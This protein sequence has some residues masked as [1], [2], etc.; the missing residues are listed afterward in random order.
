MHGGIG[1][2]PLQTTGGCV[3]HGRGRIR[4]CGVG[5]VGLPFASAGRPAVPR[6]SA[7]A[8]G[9]VERVWGVRAEVHGGGEGVWGAGFGRYGKC[10]GR[11]CE[12]KV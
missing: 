4:R 2:L 5:G 8:A 9:G 1:G 3:Q 10:R 12:G 6:G 7:A 11:G